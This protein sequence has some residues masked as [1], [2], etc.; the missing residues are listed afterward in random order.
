ML[1]II[2]IGPLAIQAPGLILLAGIWVGLSISEKQSHKYGIPAN[3]IYNLVFI[4]LI[5]GIL[6]ARFSYII[7]F[8]NAFTS[9][10]IS[11]ISL[12]P[13]MLDLW[14]G[15]AGAVIGAMIYGSKK[16]LNL[17]ATLD[18]LTPLFAIMS[19]A[20]GVSHIASG[21]AFG[22]PSDLPLAIELWGMRRHPSQFYE[23][24]GAI[25]IF[26]WIYYKIRKPQ[27]SKPGIIFLSFIS[28]TAGLHI[29]LEFF[30]G[31]SRIIYSG[32]RSN[33][34]FAWII[35]LMSLISIGKINQM[36]DRNTEIL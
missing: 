30:R 9:N 26:I 12:N 32:F 13:T 33:Q 17:W 14:G 8:P 15:I 7:R 19:I 35:L 31:D 21:S 29:F 3:I 16:G 4:S 1:P 20:I 24:I 25:L 11:I 36:H 28:A 27:L 5:C 34:V 22:S 6:T 18:A 23:T 2:S 10:P